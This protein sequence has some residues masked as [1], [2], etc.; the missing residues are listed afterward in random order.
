MTGLHLRLLRDLII[1]ENVDPQGV[2]RYLIR[3]PATNEQFEL[4]EEELFLCRQLDETSDPTVIQAAL[5]SRF[6]VTISAEQLVDFY[7]EMREL[8]L[9]TA[10]VTETSPPTV[11]QVAELEVP[12]TPEEPADATRPLRPGQRY[13][14]SLF[15][16]GRMMAWLAQRLRWLH[17]IVWGLAPGVPLA[18]LIL[19][20]HQPQYLRELRGIDQ[21]GFHLILKLTVGLFCVNLLSKLLQG[22]T[23]AYY[24]GQVGGFGVRLAF[25]IIPRFF[26][27]RGMRHLPRRERLWI[28]AV[29]L[30][31]KLGFFVLG[32][33]VWQF[34]LHSPSRLGAYGLVLGHLALAEALFII[35]PLWRAE[36]Y[37]WLTTYLEFPHLRERAFTVMR[38]ALRNTHPLK[39]LSARE[40]YALLAYGVAALA[41][42]LLI[43]GIVFFG[44][45]VHLETRFHGVGVLLFLVLITAFLA[46]ALPYLKSP[47][48]LRGSAGFTHQ[49]PLA[50]PTEYGSAMK[51]PQPTSPATPVRKL[52]KPRWGRW[53]LRLGFVIVTIVI[54][55]LPY[56]YEVTG[57]AVLLP[58]LH[59]EVHT[60][61]PGIVT[62][63]SIHENQWVKEGDTLASIDD[64]KTHY[65]VDTAKAAIEKK[66]QELDLLLAGQKPEA[67][68]YAQQQV[69][70]ARVKA[71]HSRELEKT[72]YPYYKNGTV[73][74]LQYQQALRDA[75]VDEA[76][77]KVAEANLVLVKS[78]PLPQ[79]VAI[80]RAELQQLKG[81]LDY[82]QEQL[83]ATDLDAPVEGR[84]I[85]PNLEFK[86]GV[87]LKEG[88]L[89]A[90]LEDIKKIQVEMLIPETDISLVHLNAPVTLRVWPYPLRDFKGQVSLIANITQALPDNPNVRVVRVLALIDNPDEL[91]KT[92]MTGY[93][94]IAAGQEPVIVAFTR[95][96][97]RF[98]MLEIWSWLP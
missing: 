81:Q 94:K 82:A 97:V 23:S 39:M 4:G 11:A 7:Q 53:L 88:D 92:Q 67:I 20:H 62:E 5:A 79:E 41:Y 71:I 40:K 84:V 93:A 77:L 37:A 87:Y 44:A 16:S 66:Q 22:I 80:K 36:G 59:I 58:S 68:A 43:F 38:L 61:V 50:A 98:V 63:V 74:G 52:H 35:N 10:T 2:H 51:P 95:A 28:Y 14:W 57:S 24:G 91:L 85:T 34:N 26:V 32:I 12:E 1:R 47:P 30:L 65:D 21:V 78:P 19:L 42:V 33:F 72:L 76:G 46:W 96:L 55:S 75:D 60:K 54:L 8:G 13:R 45:A 9:L 15:E 18:L 31:V 25:G 83:D 48:K 70:A 90:T 3:N 17:W 29:P 27:K 89:F 86:E 69:A 56:S 73:S 49:Q 6:G 64:L